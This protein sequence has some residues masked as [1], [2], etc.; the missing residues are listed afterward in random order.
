M[1]DRVVLIDSNGAPIAVSG[2]GDTA[3]AAAVAVER[4]NSQG[5]TLQYVPDRTLNIIAVASRVIPSPTLTSLKASWLQIHGP[6]LKLSAFAVPC[7]VSSQ[8]WQGTAGALHADIEDLNRELPIVRHCT[9]SG[10]QR[11][12]A[13]QEGGEKC[14][15]RLLPD[16]PAEQVASA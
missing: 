9:D 10:R 14:R 8:A 7:A 2:P 15:G 3:G 4:Q 1:H 13:V 16:L 6:D 12:V 5:E 11:M